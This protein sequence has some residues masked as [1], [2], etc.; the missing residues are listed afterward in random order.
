MHLITIL[1]LSPVLANAFTILVRTEG[2][3]ELFFFS[4]EKV[5]TID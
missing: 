3:I 4:E 5:F 1:H 2:H